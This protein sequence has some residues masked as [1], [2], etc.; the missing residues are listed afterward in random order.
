VVTVDGATA[1]D[2]VVSAVG[3]TTA[4]PVH[5][6]VFTAA[7]ETALVKFTQAAE[8]DQTVLIDNVMIVPGGTVVDQIGLTAT[9]TGANL[10]L[11]W[12][13]SAT[14]YLLQSSGVLP[15]TNWTDV[16][17]P[18]VIENGVKTVTVPIGADDMFFR[19]IKR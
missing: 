6:F 1:Q 10:R 12:S 14:G 8:G 13:A 3:G 15:A 19:L 4:Y 18:E 5:Q 11:S 9:V 16:T 17:Q 7:G 2:Q